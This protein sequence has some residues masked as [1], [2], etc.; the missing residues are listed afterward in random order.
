MREKKQFLF[1]LVGLQIEERSF[2][3]LLKG[4]VNSSMPWQSKV[5][6]GGGSA[7]NLLLTL[8]NEAAHKE[9]RVLK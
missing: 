2:K 1:K 5:T 8:N 4:H 6:E 3:K 9:G 7:P